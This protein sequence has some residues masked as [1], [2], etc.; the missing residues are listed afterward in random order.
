M[1]S[2]ILLMTRRL[3]SAKGSFPNTFLSI[4]GDDVSNV[5]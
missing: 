4:D 3:A 5:T 2:M 1:I